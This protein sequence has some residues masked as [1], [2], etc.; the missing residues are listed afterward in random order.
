MVKRTFQV[1]G[2]NGY[3][4][5]DE[6]HGTSCIRTVVAGITKKQAQLIAGA[7]ID[8]YERGFTDGMYY[9]QEGV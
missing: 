7:C 3:F 8:A 4:A 5:V 9:A 1:Q 6:Y 2:R